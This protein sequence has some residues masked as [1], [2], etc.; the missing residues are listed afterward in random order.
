M[1]C[2]PNEANPLLHIRSLCSVCKHHIKSNVKSYFPNFRKIFFST[3]RSQVN[4]K[5]L[6]IYDIS[7]CLASTHME[8]L[9]S[10]PMLQT[11]TEFTYREILISP[12][13][14]KLRASSKWVF[15]ANSENWMLSYITYYINK[16]CIDQILIAKDWSRASRT[17][18]W[19]PY[20]QRFSPQWGFSCL[21]ASEVVKASPRSLYSYGFSPACFR[22]CLLRPE[23]S[24]KAFPQY[25]HT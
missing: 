20:I 24:V 25:W 15:T 8:T 17:I 1:C 5:K 13:I 4:K 10:F 21:L 9:F 19:I 16:T 11:L 23:C 3:V 6:K 18:F 2:H 12:M 22:K 7:I 14:L